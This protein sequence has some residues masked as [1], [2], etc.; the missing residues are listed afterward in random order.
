M[1]IKKQSF[2]E[3]DVY[4]SE[5]SAWEVSDVRGRN[6]KKEESYQ[7]IKWILIYIETY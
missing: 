3:M 1:A 2:R 5:I 4:L 6:K 7:K